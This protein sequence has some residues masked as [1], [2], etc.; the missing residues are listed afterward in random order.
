MKCVLDH[1]AAKHSDISKN[2]RDSCSLIAFDIAELLI[3]AGKE[4]CIITFREDV[5]EHGYIH[6]KDIIPRHYGGNVV[7]ASHSVACAD[8][9][10]YD[11]LLNRPILLKDYCAAAF[12]ESIAMRVSFTTS[13]IKKLR[14][15]QPND[16]V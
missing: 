9:I 8:A 16:N 6:P 11:P 14:Q 1:L 10:V 7:W 12:G 2:Y 5:R 13:Q 15:P 3:D 4:P